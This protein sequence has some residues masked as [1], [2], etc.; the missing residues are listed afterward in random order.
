M[1]NHKNLVNNKFF[2][3]AYE[4]FHLKNGR[5]LIRSHAFQVVYINEAIVSCTCTKK[6][7]LIIWIF[8]SYYLSLSSF[9]IPF[10]NSY[11]IMFSRLVLLI[12]LIIAINSVAGSRIKR[13]GGGGRSGGGGGL[14]GGGG[15]SGGGG[16][17]IFVGG[18]GGAVGG[19]GSFGGGGASG[20]STGS[21]GSGGDLGKLFRKEFTSLILVYQKHLSYYLSHSM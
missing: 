20:G 18:G 4:Y 13:Q 1:Q 17:E 9:Y 21:G 3:I 5:A 8:V 11:Y 12:F 16:G 15:S 14:G 7:F 10:F 6:L 2:P 19:G